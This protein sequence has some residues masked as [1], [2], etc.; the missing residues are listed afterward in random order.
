MV[1][2]QTV[3]SLG[4]VKTAQAPGGLA[5][6]DLSER[7]SV[8]LAR[9]ADEIR[10]AQLLRYQVF[11]E[12]NGAKADDK[13]KA[14][15]LDFDQF[16]D[17]ADHLIVVDTDI[18]DG[19]KG[20][21][22]TYRLLRQDIAQQ[23]NG[24]YTSGEFDI[25]SLMVPGGNTM[26][27]GRSCVLEKYR[28]R[29]V[30]QKLW[31]GIS[32]YVTQHNVVMLFG[33]ASIHGVEIDKISDQLA[34][35]YHNHL[36]PEDLRP[37]AL[38]SR[39]VDMNLHGKDDVDNRAVFSALPPLLKGYLRIGCFIGDGAVIDHD[40]NTTDVCIVLSTDRVTSRYRKHYERRNNSPL[41]T[42]KSDQRGE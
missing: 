9:N 10:A 27:L 39:Y 37:R 2:E 40:F 11:Y 18:E 25:S 23:H 22:G 38:E 7:V 16:D 31:G 24:F 26:E 13:I 3:Q 12:E 1:D 15:R 30:I 14:L 19:P 41:P 42:R 28:T 17:I 21:V 20:I 32:E 5:A 8:R 4:E 36:A 6:S 34:Y 33:C 35:L 29:P